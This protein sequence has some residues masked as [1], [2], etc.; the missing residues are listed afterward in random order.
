M[1]NLCLFILSLSCCVS[2]ELWGHTTWSL[3]GVDYRVDTLSHVKIGPATTQTSLVLTGPVTQKVFYTTTDFTNPDVD[4]KVIMGKDNLLSNV[5]VPNMPASHDDDE[6]VY[7]AGVNADFIGGMGPIGTT[8][9]DGE[10]YKSY[11]GNDWD[12]FA[13][14][15]DRQLLIGTPYVSYRLVSPNAGASRMDAVNNTRGNN[16]LILYTSRKGAN[17]GTSTGGVEVGAVA[18]DGP[19][20]ASGVTQMRVTAAPVEGVGGMAIPDN[21]FVLSG[22]GSYANT[23]KNMKEGEI[24]EITPTITMNYSAVSGVKEMCGGRPVILQNGEILNTSGVLDH[25][26][27]RQPRTAVGFNSDFTKVVMLV[28]DG[29]QMGGSAGMTSKDLAALMQCAGCTEAINFDGGGSSTLYVKELGVL[30][31][32]SDGGNRAVKNGLFLTVPVQ[33]DNSIA[34]IRFADYVK[35]AEKGELYE[36]VIYGYNSKG[37]LVDTG[38]EGFALQC[39]E[40]LG[41]VQ[42]DGRSVLLNGDGT[43]ALTA[44]YDGLTASI[45]VTVG[46]DAGVESVESD[47]VKI[48][49]NP[50]GSGENVS[51]AL[52]GDALVSVYDSLGRMVL[53]PALIEKGTAALPVGNLPGG[54]YFVSVDT[55]N[56]HVRNLKLVIK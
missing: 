49:P 51:I 38:V 48:F 5:T 34:E 10:L 36:P 55:G 44:V 28:V 13:V 24:F 46:D 23:L 53:R 22:T 25:L 27:S 56:G 31:V 39:D 50:V 14:T 16:E 33:D 11:K 43:Y 54:M 20:K 29:R 4:L 1:R 32:P 19:L 42:A 30:N 3:Q 41:E 18:V 8:V 15:A 2:P 21:G 7:F 6:N 12:A 26:S 52:D 40:A 35:K 17:T 47:A 45:A 9:V 37:L